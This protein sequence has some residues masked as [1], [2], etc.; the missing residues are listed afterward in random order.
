MNRNKSKNSG[1]TTDDLREDVEDLREDVRELAHDAGRYAR[2]KVNHIAD[3]VRE[4][5]GERLDRGR[6]VVTDEYDRAIEYV[7][8]NPL[9]AVS[10]GVVLG[11]ALSSLFRRH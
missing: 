8:R 1:V 9:A 11:M 2:Q 7:R 4:S 10:I 3:S 6:A 5:T